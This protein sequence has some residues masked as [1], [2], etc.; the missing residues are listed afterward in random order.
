MPTQAQSAPL[1]QGIQSPDVIVNPTLFYG[2]TRRQRYA[3]RG[4]TA[5]AGI[6]ATDQVQLR[7]SGIVAGLEVRVQG[8]VTFAGVLGATAMTYDWPLNIVRAFRLSANGQSNLINAAGLMV[9]AHEFVD[10][11]KIQDQ[12][13]TQNVAA[14]AETEGTLSLGH[15]DWGTNAAGNLGPGVA[16]AAIGAHTFDLTYFVPVAA[17]QVSLIGAV[18]AQSSATNLT[19]EIQWNTEAGVVTLAAGCTATWAVNYSVT[20]VVYTIPNVNGSYV[21]PDLSQF[22]QLAQFRQNGIGANTNEILLPGTGVGRNLLRVMHNA[23]S[24]GIPLRQ[25]DA[26]INA[27]GW[28]YGGNQIPERY[29]SGQPFRAMN[30]RLC[31]CDI[32]GGVWGIGIWDFASENALRDV[33]DESTTSDLRILIGLVAAPVG[34]FAEVCQETLFAAP[35]GA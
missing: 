25:T 6:G 14:A 9:R 23:W 10:N 29:D 30:E 5:F 4:L 19:L 17:H 16:P 24:G 13:R 3:M 33:V 7:Q 22:H 12:G 27:A 2:A 1:I 15:D 28:G 11:P 18:Y 21:I 35:V 34:G 32:G 20:G 26:N 8:T 31:G